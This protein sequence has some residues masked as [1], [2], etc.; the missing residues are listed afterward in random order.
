MRFSIVSSIATVLLSGFLAV[1][2]PVHVDLAP[3]PAPAPEPLPRAALTIPAILANGQ[4]QVDAVTQQI[5]KVVPFGGNTTQQ[6][7]TALVSSLLSRVQV[8]IDNVN[9]QLL[10]V[11]DQPWDV[12]GGGADPTTAQYALADLAISAVKAVAPVSAITETYPELQKSVDAV[13][14]SV[15][16]IGPVALKIN[17][18]H[19]WGYVLIGVGAV[20]TAIGT[21]LLP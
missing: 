10:Q 21:A 19:V 3:A 20:L 2:S 9:T 4:A 17:W 14:Q 6:V 5:R 8:T 7:D 13:T 1:A 15:V 16:N 12:V 18:T 11:A